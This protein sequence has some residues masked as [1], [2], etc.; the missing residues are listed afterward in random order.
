MFADSG[1]GKIKIANLDGSGVR[2][3]VTAV[4]PCPDVAAAMPGMVAAVAGWASR[5]TGLAVDVQAGLLFFTDWLGG[6]A[7]DERAPSYE[8]LPRGEL[9]IGSM[10]DRAKEDCGGA[11]RGPSIYSAPLD[12]S[13]TAQIVPSGLEKPW[14]IAVDALSRKVYW[15]DHGTKKVQRANYD[16]TAV[17]DLVTDGLSEPRGIAVDPGAGKMY[18]ADA[19]NGSRILKA[20]LD[21][22]IVEPIVQLT[23]FATPDG[24]ALDLA[25]GKVYWTEAYLRHIKRANLDGSDV[26]KVLHV[27]RDSLPSGIFIDSLAGKIYWSDGKANKI[28]RV[29]LDG[30]E[31]EDVVTLEGMMGQP[32]GVVVVDAPI[33]F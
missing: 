33:Q 1:D 13:S 5:P 7:A 4:T 25:R 31:P 11:S 24:V 12:G 23:E 28:Q 30:S 3:F 29:S 27:S 18:W 22:S 14:G 17:E 8:A 9:D 21:G 32:W 6:Y 10:L 19:L 26:E 2:S 15:T 20:N 16:G